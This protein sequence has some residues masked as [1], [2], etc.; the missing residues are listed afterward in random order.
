MFG[1]FFVAICQIPKIARG[2]ASSYKIQAFDGQH[3]G[4]NTRSH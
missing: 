1:G 4:D 3:Y 2:H